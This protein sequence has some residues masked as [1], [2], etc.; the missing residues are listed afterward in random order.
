MQ[1]YKVL[2]S[3]NGTDGNTVFRADN[4]KPIFTGSIIALWNS[5]LQE[6]MKATNLDFKRGLPK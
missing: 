5:L 1:D 2:Q 3:S 4:R 6:K